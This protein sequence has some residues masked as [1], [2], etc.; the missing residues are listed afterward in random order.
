MRQRVLLPSA[1]VSGLTDAALSGKPDVM[2]AQQQHQ[3]DLEVERVLDGLPED[4]LDTVLA[5]LGSTPKERVIR[6][7]WVIATAE[8]DEISAVK[9]ARTAG[10]SWEE[11]GR[12]LGVT[13]QSAHERFSKLIE[14]N[15]N[16]RDMR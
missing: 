13:R 11:I 12:W 8:E 7:G 1:R 14:I 16:V 9:E 2:N 3:D 5:L 15:V 6:A 10:T 4:A